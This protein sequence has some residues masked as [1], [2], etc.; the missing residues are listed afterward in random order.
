MPATPA[1]REIDM[2]PPTDLR[3]KSTLGRSEADEG[4]YEKLNDFS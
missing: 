2:P 3:G 1:R 4:T